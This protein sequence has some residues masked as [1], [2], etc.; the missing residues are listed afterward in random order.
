[1]AVVQVECVS[2][3]GV[4]AVLCDNVLFRLLS[5]KCDIKRL[6]QT[7]LVYCDPRVDRFVLWCVWCEFTGKPLADYGSAL[8]LSSVFN[9][10][11][12]IYYHELSL[13]RE[14][15]A[16]VVCLDCVYRHTLG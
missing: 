14:T 8:Y 6:T 13:I 10:Q 12:N 4:L 15:T 16:T 7:F 11:P 3:C 5:C 2:V 1:M 9:I